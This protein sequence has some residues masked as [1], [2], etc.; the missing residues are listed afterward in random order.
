MKSLSPLR[1]LVLVGV[2]LGAG[3]VLAIPV[4]LNLMTDIFGGETSFTMT[5]AGDATNLPF[6]SANPGIGGGDNFADPGEL[7]SSTAYVFE[8]DLAPGDYEFTINDSF[9]DGICCVFGAGDYTLTTPAGD[10]PS[11]SGGAFGSSETI[12]FSL[13]AVPLPTTLALL[14]LGLAGL[15]WSRRRASR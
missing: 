7:A 6:D 1:S 10:F 15:G 2:C 4:T 5:A 8:W 9:G 11:P 14:G 12:E 13:A 3:S